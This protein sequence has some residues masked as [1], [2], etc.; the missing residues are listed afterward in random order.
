MKT[1]VRL[2]AIACGP[3]ERKN[4]ILV[5]V[6]SKNRYIEG[7]VSTKVEVDGENSTEKISEIVKHSKFND[8]IRLLVLNGI[9]VA[10]L[11]IF[12]IGEF[13]KV[14]GVKV[15]SVTRKKPHPVELIKAL[16]EF[17][18]I[19]KRDVRS[20]IS[21]VNGL[22]KINLFKT[23]NFYA[24]T[25]LSREDSNKFISDAFEQ[26]RIAHLIARGVSSK[27]SKGRI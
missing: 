26:L 23:D 5:G 13:E 25:T 17:S 16:K 21:L 15:I 1:G 14:T 18:K 7:I 20:R 6:V 12:N 11:N 24:Q 27:E 3:L 9:G 19:K 4:T 22:T 2:L 10:G 8:Q